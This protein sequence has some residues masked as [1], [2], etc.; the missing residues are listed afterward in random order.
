MMI[1]LA[2]VVTSCDLHR[3]VVPVLPPPVLLA[4]KTFHMSKLL[5]DVL[6]IVIV[7]RLVA[8]DASSAA[9]DSTIRL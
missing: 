6:G 5:V 7:L 1:P 9:D 8:E 3:I 4:R 2:E